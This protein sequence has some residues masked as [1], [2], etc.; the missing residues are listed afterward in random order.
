MSD[1]S[2]SA[3]PGSA[4][5][6]AALPLLAMIAVLSAFFGPA[7]ATEGTFLYRDNG[8][9][10]LPHKRLVAEALARGEL[11]QWNPYGGL[12]HPLVAGA[13]DAVQHPFNALLLV[14]P[15]ELGFKAW[16]LLSFFVAACGAFAWARALSLGSAP[17]AAAGIGF[18]LTGFLVSSTDNY[19][20]LTALASVPL[21]LAAAHAFVSRAGPGRALLLAVTSGF[22]AAAGDPQ[23]WGMALG[24]LPAYALLFVT[25]SSSRTRLWRGLLAVLVCFLGAAPFIVPVVAW[26]P[27]SSRGDPLFWMELERYNLLPVRL[28]ELGLPGL[29]STSPIPYR[30][31]LYEAYAGNAFTWVPWVRSEYL[32]ATLLALALF[33]ASR[34]RRAALA[35]GGAALFAWAA[36]GT[37]AGFGQLAR[38]LPVIS[39]FRYWEKVAIFTALLVVA[40]GAFGIDA[41]LR[42]PARSRRFAFGA[43]AAGFVLLAAHL[44]ARLAPGALVP[45]VGRPGLPAESAQFAEN[46][47]GAFLHAGGAL[48]TL[49]LFALAVS[50]GRLT[51]RASAIGLV[52][53][54]ALDLAI[55]NSDAYVLSPPTLARP[56][57]ALAEAL[58]RGGAPSRVVTPFPLDDRGLE[59]YQPFEWAALRGAVGLQS[60]W[61]VDH[62]VGN[63]EPYT[64]MIAARAMRFRLR[65]GTRHQ[66]PQVGMWGFGHVVVPQGAP[67][68]DYGLSPPYDVV[69]TEPATRSLLV[70]IPHRPRAYLAEEVASTDRRGAMEFV[71]DPASV[72]SRRTV[73]EGPSIAGKGG[74]SANI[75]V[76]TRERVVVAVD[77]RSPSLLVLSDTYAPGWTATVDGAVAEILP[78]NYLARGVWIPAGRHEVVFRYRTPGLVPGWIIAC[79]GFVGL[80]AAAGWR[81]IST[82]RRG[83]A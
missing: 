40:A 48:T 23:S 19:Q 25:E 58:R 11:P 63:F 65:T 79:A 50:T 51:E 43:A 26:L 1:P 73:V 78:A 4:R 69:A 62:R 76:D 39:G 54:V 61:N 71:L 27:H 66:I 56:P 13:V 68:G 16:G 55:A 28:A 38:H 20:Y 82:G 70:R 3:D 81:R 17:A 74:G 24:L 57:S 47:V 60:G 37:G 21:L 77:A 9:M 44:A 45:I 8:R 15:F 83:S 53:V 18:A 72:V 22:A 49:G 59:P 75:V 35:L 29:L 5:S 33:G 52:A 64:G 36:M 67:G 41:L 2:T 46:L 30:S 31:S 14:L 10:H 32:G 6:R 34:S 7:I 42:E 12:G 80:G